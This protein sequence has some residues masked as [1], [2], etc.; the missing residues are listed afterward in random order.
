MRAPAW[1]TPAAFSRV[2]ASRWIW[3]V[4]GSR[5]I[6][7]G[8]FERGGPANRRPSPPSR[9]PSC[10]IRTVRTL[11]KADRLWRRLSCGGRR[12]SVAVIAA[13]YA[14]GVLRAQ[15]P[16]WL[17]VASMARV[18]VMLGRISMDLIAIDVSDCPAWRAPGDHGP[19]AR[20]RRC[21][22][23]D[24]AQAASKTPSRMKF[25]PG[26]GG[27]ANGDRVYRGRAR[28]NPVR[29]IG[30]MPPLDTAPAGRRRGP[31]RPCAARSAAFSPP[32]FFPAGRPADDGDRLPCPC[33]WSASP[34]CS[35]AR[36][37]P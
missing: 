9:R 26:M 8:P 15:S 32:W 20:P 22:L 1:P 25:L 33:R 7:G 19:T 34:P 13:G 10:K 17:W 3:C 14:D 24:A 12:L 18:G 11:A 21:L 2:R 4:L 16:A 23:D 27:R 37:W 28:L 31:V 6:G 5:S 35:P 30:R 29:V 36:P